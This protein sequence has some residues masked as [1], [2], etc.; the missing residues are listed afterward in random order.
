MQVPKLAR[1]RGIA[2]WKSFVGQGGYGF[3]FVS[4]VFLNSSAGRFDWLLKL[5]LPGTQD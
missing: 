5:S 3:V 4:R 1:L 2:D